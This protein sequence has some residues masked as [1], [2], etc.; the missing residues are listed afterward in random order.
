MKTTDSKFGNWSLFFVPFCT[1]SGYSF[2][3]NAQDCGGFEDVNLQVT[4]KRSEI[5]EKKET[6]R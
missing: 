6:R 1:A 2:G 4:N 5:W 3:N